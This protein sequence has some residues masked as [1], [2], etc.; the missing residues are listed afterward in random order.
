MPPGGPTMHTH[1]SVSA[2]CEYFEE[3]P[4]FEWCGNFLLVLQ[5]QIQRAQ[6]IDGTL[7]GK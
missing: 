2:P 4:T 1:I 5:M 3:K 7:N 6:C